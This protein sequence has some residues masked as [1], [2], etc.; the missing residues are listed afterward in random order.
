MAEENK[1][2]IMIVDDDDFLVDMYVTKFNNSGI[3]VDVCKSGQ[4]L[5]DKLKEGYKSDVILL[6]VVMPGLNGLDTLKEIK[7]GNIAANIP[8]IMLTNQNDEK[9][10]TEAKSLGVSGYIVKSAVTPSELVTEVTNII[11]N[12]SSK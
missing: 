1:Y 9:D 8:I 12:K 3:D 5:I 6:D 10:L 7:N 2:R 11:K 4:S